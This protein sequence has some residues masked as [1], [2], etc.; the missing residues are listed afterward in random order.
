MC[1]WKDE[2]NEKEAGVDP[3]F[4]KQLHWY[5]QPKVRSDYM[6]QSVFDAVDFVNTVNR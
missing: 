2:K 5:E 3:S 1:V 6:Q 4:L